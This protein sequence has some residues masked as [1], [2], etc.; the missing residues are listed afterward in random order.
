MISVVIIF[1]VLSII[2]ALFELIGIW[3]LRKKD[4]RAFLS[5]MVCG[6]VWV[7]VALLSTPINL[8]LLLVIPITTTFNVFAWLKWNEDEK[9]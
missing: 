3:L 6:V 5:F 1:Q 8:G 4:K 7:A 9:L 2:A